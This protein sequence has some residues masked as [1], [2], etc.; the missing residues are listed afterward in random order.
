MRGEAGHA[1]TVVVQEAGVLGPTVWPKPA[2]I[3]MIPSQTRIARPADRHHL[4]LPEPLQHVWAGALDGFPINATGFF[5]RVPF[6]SGPAPADPDLHDL[7]R[8][9]RQRGPKVPSQHAKGP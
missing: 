4:R 8:A 2:C 7:R 9:L 5:M 3:H 6:L 1:G